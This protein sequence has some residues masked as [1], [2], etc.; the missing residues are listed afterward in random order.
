MNDQARNTHPDTAG[1]EN[2]L[3][4]MLEVCHPE[5]VDNTR[6][7]Q[8]V[9]EKIMREK[10]ARKRRIRRIIFSSI[11]AAACVAVMVVLAFG[12]FTPDS[13]PLSGSTLA[14]IKKAG[15]QELIVNPGEKAEITLP[16]GSRLIA[17]SRT[18]VLYPDHFKGKDRRIFANGEVYLEVAK[19]K[20][21]PFV[22]ES[23][24]FEVR[25]L[26]T[27]FNI[28]NSSDSTASVVLVEGAVEVTTESDHTFRMKPNDLAELVN[29]EMVAL[30]KVD[31][32]DFTAWTDGL[33]VL[34]GEVLSSLIQRLGHHYD[35]TISCD[36]ALSDVRF[37]GKLDLGEGVDHVLSA[38]KEIVPM[39]I[40]REGDRI[41][42]KSKSMK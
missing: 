15:Y 21:H 25:V 37:Y 11:S 5:S 24:G 7:K 14:E 27:V 20:D 41:T 4:L 12:L 34:K 30:Q 31:T 38:I 10:M 40:S 16:D 1:E 3:E 29:G 18:R 39:E 19:D 33:L 9:R 6:I 13:K 23:E 36:S 26:G 42:M 22:V 17:N 32:S 8:L 28:R 2:R 35:V